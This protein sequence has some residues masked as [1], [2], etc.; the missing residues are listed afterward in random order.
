M[1]CK[2]V[3]LALGRTEVKSA[4]TKFGP[5]CFGTSSIL[6]YSILTVDILFGRAG[7]VHPLPF[8][9]LALSFSFQ[10]YTH[11]RTVCTFDVPFDV[12]IPVG[13]VL[14]SLLIFSLIVVRTV[15]SNYRTSTFASTSTTFNYITISALHGVHPCAPPPLFPTDPERDALSLLGPVDSKGGEGQRSPSPKSPRSAACGR[16]LLPSSTPYR[17]PRL[18]PVQPW[19]SR[20][21]GSSPLIKLHNSP[22]PAC[23]YPSPLVFSYE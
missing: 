22:C 11:R 2:P 18:A 15:R 9:E 6:F 23:P 10:L 16:Y 21:S 8:P 3:W 19:N 17:R 13:G 20:T 12:P 14:L 1:L 4:K 5:T 7:D